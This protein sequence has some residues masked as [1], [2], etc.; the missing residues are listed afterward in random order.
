[1]PAFSG[2][3]KAGREKD[4]EG[5]GQKRAEVKARLDKEGRKAGTEGDDGWD[6]EVLLLVGNGL[7]RR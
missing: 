7:C 2:R 4:E 5:A 3:Q 1:M 6:G